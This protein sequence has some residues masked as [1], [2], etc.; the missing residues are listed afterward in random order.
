MYVYVIRKVNT[1]L[2]DKMV[3]VADSTGHKLDRQ[4]CQIVGAVPDNAAFLMEAELQ[5]LVQMFGP[6]VVDL[7]YLD[8]FWLLLKKKKNV[9]RRRTG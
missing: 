6:T 4:I 7:K 3:E 2:H 9:D 8:A 1:D 5:Q